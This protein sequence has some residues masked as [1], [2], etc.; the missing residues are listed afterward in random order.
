MLPG[1]EMI[2]CPNL[3]VSPE[4]MQHIVR[5]ES[6]ANPYAIGVVGGQL[7]RQPSNIGEAVATVKM[8]DA[9]GYNYSLGLAQ[10]NR[11]NFTRY[12]LDT[13]EKV[14]DR[15]ANLTAGSLILADCYKSAG[16]DW[17]KAFSCYYS[18]NFTTGFKDG[19][20]QKIQASIDNS[21]NQARIQPQQA[22][23]LKPLDVLPARSPDN[24]SP[25]A[26]QVF[27]QT[28]ASGSAGYR[29]ALRSLAIDRAATATV[30]AIANAVSKRLP[31]MASGGGDLA[32]TNV[33]AVDEEN[34]KNAGLEAEA[35]VPPQTSGSAPEN[36]SA[37][38]AKASAGAANPDSNEVFV[39]QVRGPNDPIEPLAPN[40]SVAV[41]DAKSS[42]AGATATLRGSRD[43]AFV[44]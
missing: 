30:G 10:V 22:I 40:Q 37:V 39:P 33:M 24:T 9:K 8:L 34:E 26:A 13:Y 4:V 38:A 21:Y 44:F 36:A 23:E 18:G 11:A 42:V 5:V 12:G 20:V 41:P 29:V 1:L 27:Q 43:D 2:A 25:R 19:Y 3:A 35:G 28:Y 14:F 32:N 31:A 7:V 17:G 15:C 16:S 6:S